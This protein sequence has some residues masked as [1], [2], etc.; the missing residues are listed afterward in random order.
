MV[1][2]SD[3]LMVGWQRTPYEEHATEPSSK[4]REFGRLTITEGNFRP[5]ELLDDAG[6]YP[7][8][9]L[10]DSRKD[11]KSNAPC[12]DEEARSVSEARLQES[13]VPGPRDS[14]SSEIWDDDPSFEQDLPTGLGIKSSFSDGLKSL[15]HVSSL[16][17]LPRSDRRKKR[18]LGSLLRSGSLPATTVLKPIRSPS[19]GF[20]ASPPVG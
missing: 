12:L 3:N 11:I 4:R 8:T 1:T 2:S 19:P 7:V 18:S 10:V 6:G 16:K 15:V 5:L 17:F 9:S 14:Q 13:K 20:L